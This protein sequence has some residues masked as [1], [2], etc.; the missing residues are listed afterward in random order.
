MGENLRILF[1]LPS[2]HRV[3]RGAEVAF[4]ALATELANGGDDVTLIGS[5]AGR[6]GTPYRYLRAP[7][8]P[9]E[10]F[11]IMPSLPIFRNET[12]WE[13]L[14]FFPGLL[15]RFRPG[16][17]DVTLTCSYPFTQWALRR[18]TAAGPRPRHVFVTQNGD[19]AARSQ[20]SEYKFFHCDGL[21]C[22]NPD[23]F[24]NNR[25]RW[26]SALIP[27][28]VEVERFSRGV[29]ERA[30]FA[31]PEDARVIVMVSALIASKRVADGVR[32]VAKMP[33][34]YLLCAGDGP[35]RSEIDNLAASLMPGRF[36][37]VSVGMADMPVVYHSAD[38][39]LH[40]S[41]EEPFGNVFVEAMASGLPIVAHDTARTRW[42]VGDQELLCD[43][44]DL[45]LLVEALT[46]A[47]LTDRA[48]ASRRSARA[49]TFSWRYVAARYRA[50]LADV[51]HDGLLQE[52]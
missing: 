15:R 33:G 3:D 22:T 52:Q 18:P 50:F 16:D 9:R 23:Y 40:L 48:G 11:E 1:A 25:A 26:R 13:D 30:R 43:S 19:W 47:I 28:G 12:A 20:R 27:N 2:L 46:R 36:R 37:R 41:T 51:M 35:L 21:V 10:R 24:E 8:I 44:R 4:L 29:A 42:I 38:A 45:H 32:A 39:L 17:Y 7:V 14:T 5:G 31:I 6:K 49:A 34:V